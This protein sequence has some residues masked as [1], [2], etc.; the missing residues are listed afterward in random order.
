MA[1]EDRLFKNK[2][3]FQALKFF[4]PNRFI[5]IKN[6][7]LTFDGENEIIFKKFVTP[8]DYNPI[9]SKKNSLTL[10]LLMSL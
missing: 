10:H 6:K 2:N 3:I 8:M 4:D 7:M 9:L 5:N 1:I